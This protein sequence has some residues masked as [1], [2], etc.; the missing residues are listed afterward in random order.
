MN[1]KFLHPITDFI[2]IEHPLE[3]ADILFVP[4]NG[5]PDMAIRAAALW[6]QGYIPY[7]LVSGKYEKHVGRFQIVAQ[8][9]HAREGNYETESDYLEAVLLQQGIPLQAILKESEATFTYENAIYSRRLTDARHMQIDKAI[10]CCH[11]YHARR[12][13]MYYQLMFPETSFLVCPVDT[14]I[15][16]EN[17]YLTGQGIEKVLGEVERCGSQFHDII[18]GCEH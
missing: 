15:N 12:C 9:E 16:R 17:W 14:G 5:Y 1:L 13:L 7:I 10:I 11:S 2:F 8:H 4:G 3:S 18:K 6:R